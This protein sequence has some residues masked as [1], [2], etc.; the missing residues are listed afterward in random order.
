MPPQIANS[1]PYMVSPIGM[2]FQ[3]WASTL[4]IDFSSENVP[5]PPDEKNW[6]DW[7]QVLVARNIFNNADIPSP[8]MF[9]DWQVWAMRVRQAVNG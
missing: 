6:K 9:D 2:T 4:F 8:Y 5:I 3:A 7:A 1:K